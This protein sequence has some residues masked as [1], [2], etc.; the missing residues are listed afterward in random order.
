[1]YDFSTLPWSVTRSWI[2]VITYS[3]NVYIIFLDYACYFTD[4]EFE[5][6]H[7]ESDSYLTFTPAEF[8]ICIM[9]L[10]ESSQRP[11][12][13]LAIC[14]KFAVKSLLIEVYRWS[15]LFPHK[16]NKK[17]SAVLYSN[18]DVKLSTLRIVDPYFTLLIC[19]PLFA[20]YFNTSFSFEHR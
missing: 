2:S 17:R 10:K 3:R 15:F 1:M 8:F 12:I 19:C 4:L 11:L 14:I 20:I 16:R 9:F 6:A 7:R 5:I 13:A 18:D